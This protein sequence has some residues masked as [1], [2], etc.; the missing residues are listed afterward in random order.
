MDDAWRAQHCCSVCSPQLPPAPSRR[1][2]PRSR[3]SR[4]GRRSPASTIVY[5]VPPL[6]DPAQCQQMA[7]HPG[8]P[9]RGSAR[10]GAFASAKGAGRQSDQARRD[11]AGSRPTA[12][13]IG[14]PPENVI[15]TH[16]DGANRNDNKYIDNSSTFH[17]VVKTNTIGVEFIGNY[18]DVAKPRHVRADAGLA[19]PRCASCRNVTAIAGRPHLRAQ[20]DRLQETRADL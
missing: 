14:R 19:D 2:S 13:S 18:P 11:A 10:L 7:E 16:G 8:A 5:L 4:D 15:P 12:P 20:L 6:G 3:S 1:R 9:D 17:N